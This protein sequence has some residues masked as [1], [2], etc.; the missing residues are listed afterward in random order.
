[1]KIAVGMSGGVDSSVAALLLKEQGHDVIGLSMAIWDGKNSSSLK[2]RNACYGPD[3]KYDIADAEKICRMLDIPFHVIDCR[4]QYRE[5]VL[6]Y[7][8]GEYL[9]GRTP[10]PCVVCNHRIKFGSLLNT[11]RSSGLEF[12]MFATGHYAIVEYDDEN[13]RYLLK[14]SKD[15]KKDQS[16]FL[17]M[18]NQDQLHNTLF[19]LG[20]MIKNE[21]RAIAEKAGLPVSDK[22][23]SQDFYEGDY[24]ELLEVSDS[25]GEIVHVD[26]RVLGR[27]K[28]IWNYTPGQRKGLSISNSE[29][30]YVVKL[31]RRYN[32]VVVGTKDD[33]LISSF[34]VK[35]INWIDLNK[36]RGRFQAEVKTRYSQAEIKCDIEILDMLKAKVTP[37]EKAQSI[38]PGQSAVFYNNDSIIGG[39][40]IECID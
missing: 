35:N 38:S 1:M 6:T 36:H 31:D 39:G 5:E 17:Y 20:T 27:H 8:R 23:E 15:M 3:E 7:F 13:D 25:E 14:K 21:V 18:L 29:P 26:G 28:G 24:G 40:I 12:E 30:L 22:K 19:P 33:T 32:R 2:K 10:N 16:Y 4:R 11:A 37:V 34:Y 9:S